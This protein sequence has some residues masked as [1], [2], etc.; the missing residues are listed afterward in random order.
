MRELSVGTVAGHREL[1]F[2]RPGKAELQLDLPDGRILK[3]IAL[4]ADRYD[5]SEDV[6]RLESHA[7]QYSECL[8]EGSPVG[9]KLEFIT[10]EFNREFNTVGSN[11][12]N[13]GINWLVIEAKNEIERIHEQLQNIE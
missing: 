13:I 10:Q 4:F 6:T 8:R 1:L 12:I 3:E 9:R 2:I 7:T 5:I 11:T